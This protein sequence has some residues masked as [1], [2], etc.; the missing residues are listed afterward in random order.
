MRLLANKKGF[1]LN[2][3]GL[4]EG[5]IRD[6]S[7]RKKKLSAGSLWFHLH[8]FFSCLFIGNLIA[9]D[10]EEQIFEMLGVPWREPQ[11]RVTHYQDLVERAQAEAEE[12]EKKANNL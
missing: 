7:D 9:S 11:E 1:S 6:P 4:Y 5:V 8:H 2:Q 12:E 10:T 3:R